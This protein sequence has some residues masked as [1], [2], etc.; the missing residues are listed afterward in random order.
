MKFKKCR[1]CKDKFPV[2]LPNQI[3]CC[4]SCA[5]AWNFKQQANDKDKKEKAF[6]AETKRLK[7]TIKPRGKWVAEAQKEFNKYIRLRDMGDPC[8]SCGLNDHEI[9]PGPT[10]TWDCGHFIG[11]GANCTI[12]FEED[13][14][15]RQ[16]Y[17][18][19]RGSASKRDRK[20]IKRE[21]VSKEYKKRL[22]DKI[23]IERVE[24]LEGPHPVAK[25]SIEALKEIKEEY[26]NRVKVIEND[27]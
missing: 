2:E 18:C 15:H 7:Q 12:R 25:L 5:L 26:K 21:T 22:I 9:A 23:G 1:V 24:W 3:V 20:G 8:I 16:C 6:R 10:G 19:N 13:N 11:V 27:S 4:P 14:A 17:L